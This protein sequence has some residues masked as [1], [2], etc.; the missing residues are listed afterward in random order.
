M[1]LHLFPA[2]RRDNRL[3]LLD[4]IFFFLFFTKRLNLE[5][6]N[7]CSLLS[8]SHSWK[9]NSLIGTR[10]ILSKLQ[11]RPDL[12]VCHTKIMNFPTQ[13]ERK[14]FWNMQGLLSL[15]IYQLTNGLSFGE[16]DPYEFPMNYYKRATGSRT[17]T[18]LNR[19]GEERGAFTLKL[20][21]F[22]LNTAWG[23]MRLNAWMVRQALY[24]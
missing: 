14:R 22:H 13:V 6:G 18:I 24:T 23:W 19:W 8:I 10:L 20:L 3:L 5:D 16:L 2:H 17:G 12:K 11:R 21:P 7:Y 9:S 15:V 4:V 1:M